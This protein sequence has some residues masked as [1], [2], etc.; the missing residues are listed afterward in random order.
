M[1]CV[2][3]FLSPGNQMKIRLCPDSISIWKKVAYG[4]VPTAVTT[5]KYLKYVLDTPKRS[6]KQEHLLDVP[7][8]FFKLSK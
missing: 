7:K 8:T 3:E 6:L 5:P 4:F 1:I 2:A